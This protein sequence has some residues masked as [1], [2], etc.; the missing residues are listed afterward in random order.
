MSDLR[1]VLRELGERF[2]PSDALPSQVRTRVR[3]RQAVAA[4]AAA[5]TLSAVGVG[6]AAGIH[7][8]SDRA[9]RVPAVKVTLPPAPTSPSPVA[10]TDGWHLAPNPTVPGDDQ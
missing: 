6:S 4:L 5:I 1:S 2:E 8:L 10:C 9:A 7:A 3:R